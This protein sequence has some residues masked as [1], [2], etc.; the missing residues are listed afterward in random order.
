MG[1]ALVVF[2]SPSLSV[3]HKQGFATPDAG[4]A[5]MKSTK[6]KRDFHTCRGNG[7]PK[8][9]RVSSRQWSRAGAIGKQNAASLTK[10]GTE[11]V[12]LRYGHRSPRF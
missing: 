9:E 5:A 8:R 4:Y 2:P 12:K 3:E 6:H 10:L 1:I 7:Q 11:A